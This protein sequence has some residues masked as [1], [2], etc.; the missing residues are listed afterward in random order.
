MQAANPENEMLQPEY[1]ARQELKK[2][3][4]S[5]VARRRLLMLLV[6]ILKATRT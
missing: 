4:P 5:S 3:E 1:R 2:L 6:E